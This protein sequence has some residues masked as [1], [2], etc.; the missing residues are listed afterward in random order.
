[1]RERERGRDH[2]REC[3]RGGG[4]EGGEEGG[5]EG[6]RE[7]EK[8]GGMEGRREGS[9]KNQSSLSLPTFMLLRDPLNSMVLEAARVQMGSS[10]ATKL[11]PSSS[12]FTLH[13]LMVLSDEP[14]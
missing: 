14:L 9:N 6:V 13:T 8:E 10:W 3:G 2:R 5:R 4:R 7:G 12:V 1:M 11:A